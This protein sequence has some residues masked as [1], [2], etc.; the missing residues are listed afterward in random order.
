MVY[1]NLWFI[2]HRYLCLIAS[3]DCNPS[4]VSSN[5]QGPECVSGC[6]VWIPVDKLCSA[7]FNCF[8]PYV[9]NASYVNSTVDCDESNGCQHYAHL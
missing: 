5:R 2:N 9:T 8:L 1:Y 7:A 4:K 3:I 6:R